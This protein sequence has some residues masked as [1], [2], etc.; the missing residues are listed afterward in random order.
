MLAKSQESVR[1]RSTGLTPFSCLRIFIRWILPVRVLAYL[2]EL[3]VVSIAKAKHG[4]FILIQCFSQRRKLLAGLRAQI[5]DSPACQQGASYLLS[6]RQIAW[7][8]PVINDAVCR[9][10]ALSQG[11]NLALFWVKFE[12]KCPPQRNKHMTAMRHLMLSF[13]TR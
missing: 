9:R 11:M 3:R 5:P 2:N 10:S 4:L 6:R 13:A 8:E 7:F 1:A 12:R